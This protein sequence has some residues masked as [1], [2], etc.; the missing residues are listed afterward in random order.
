M[1]VSLIQMNIVFGNTEVNRTRVMEMIHKAAKDKPDVIVLP[2]MWNTSFSLKDIHAIADKEGEPTKT[3]ICDLAKKYQINIVAGSIADKYDEDIYNRLYVVDRGGNVIAH[4]DKVHL[5]RHAGE[6]EYI[7]PGVEATVFNIDGIK[8]GAVL[9]YDLRFPEL[10]R[11]M[12]L[13]GA[14][15]LFVPAQWFETRIDHWKTLTTARAI[16]NQMYVVAVNRIGNEFQAIFPGNSMVIDPW[17]KI[18]AQ[19]GNEEKILTAEMDINLVDRVRK[20][21]TCFLDRNVNVYKL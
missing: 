20:K 15:V 7:K 6:Q 17:G 12:A 8:C 14:K 1:K 2:E 16:E 19:A 18:V 3:F 9:C 5:V 21:I 10:A 11:T 4:Y 13:K